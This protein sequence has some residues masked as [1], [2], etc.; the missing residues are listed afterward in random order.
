MRWDEQ[1]N[2][3]KV[4]DDDRILWLTLAP[5][6]R[7]RQAQRKIREQKILAIFSFNGVHVKKTW[8]AELFIE[9]YEVFQM[10]R[11]S[12]KDREILIYRIKS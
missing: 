10:I 4:E 9:K 3:F 2:S 11:N 8:F 1:F 5:V 12:W 7:T 6:E